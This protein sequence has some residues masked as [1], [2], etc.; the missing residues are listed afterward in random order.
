MCLKYIQWKMMRKNKHT[1]NKMNACILYSQSTLLQIIFFRVK[2][3]LVFP[4]INFLIVYWCCC[5]CC[6]WVPGRA[7]VCVCFN[8]KRQVWWKMSSYKLTGLFLWN[9]YLLQ[10]KICD[11]VLELKEALNTGTAYDYVINDLTEDIVDSEKHS[12]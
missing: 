7:H 5:I 11:C 6:K 8:Q 10:I 2:I 12:E 3:V 1:G 9:F 4:I